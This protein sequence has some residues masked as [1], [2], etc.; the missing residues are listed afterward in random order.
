MRQ[1][2][3]RQRTVKRRAKQA[4]AALAML[5]CA[6]F[7]VGVCQNTIVLP[8]I[9]L[10][11]AMVS[12]TENVIPRLKEDA[13]APASDKL[14]FLDIL[15]QFQSEAPAGKARS[16]QAYDARDSLLVL[17]PVNTAALPPMRTAHQKPALEVHGGFL[18]RNNE[19]G[20]R[21][22][23]SDDGRVLLET[24]PDTLTLTGHWDEAARAVFL[25]DGAYV[26]Y[27]EESAA[28]VPAAY[29]PALSAII[30]VD[31]SVYYDRPDGDIA[32]Y[33]DGARYGYY[34]QSTGEPCYMYYHTGQSYQFREGYGALGTSDGIMIVNR[35]ATAFFTNFGA[36]LPPE[37]SGREL[38]G[39]YQFDRGLMRVRTLAADGTVQNLV[40]TQAGTLFSLPADY[41]A[42]AYSDGVFLMEK[43]GRYGFFDYTGRWIA[44]PVYAAASA[45]C[46]G[47]AVVED[48]QGKKGV[49]DTAGS[50][51]VP[52]EF[53]EIAP[54]SGGIL[55]LCRDL[56]WVVL[57]KVK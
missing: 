20:T 11:A 44:Q 31:L 45:F 4:I 10:S 24:M 48:A 27:D 23:L 33:Y 6:L 38:L 32:L 3:Y 34:Y 30:G 2:E 17:Q 53:D 26:C 47:L 13:Q 52:L 57:Q 50:F 18:V 43:E 37:G 49:I 56:K 19:D 40:I 46:E 51:V 54:V 39:F 25:S 15:Y 14:S 21:T 36:Y 55:A 42:V 8:F 7:I 28:F 5:L 22:L 9:N 1:S 16:L 12:E 35:A 41:R 29:Q